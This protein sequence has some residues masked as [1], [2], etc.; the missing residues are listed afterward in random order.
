MTEITEDT[1]LLDIN[2]I[3]LKRWVDEHRAD[4][5]KTTDLLYGLHQGIMAWITWSSI[6]EVKRGWPMPRTLKAL[7]ELTSAQREE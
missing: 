3:E 5:S 2:P 4:S 7:K 6:P 1:D